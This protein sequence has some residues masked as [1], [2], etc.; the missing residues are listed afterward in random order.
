[1]ESIAK[2]KEAGKIAAKLLANAKKLAKPETPL[3]EIAEKI[4]N[5][6]EKLKVKFAFPINLSINEIAAH[7]TPLADD[8]TVASGLLK[9][10]IGVCIDGCISDNA[11]SIDLTPEQKYKDLIKASESAL[12]E[13]IKIAKS[14][15]EICEIGK[16]IAN[17]ITKEGFSPVR[18][19]SGHELKPYKLH[20]GLNIPNYDNRNRTKL[21]EGMI[22][23]VEPFAT[24]GAGIVQ[25]G[26]PSGI[27]ALQ[28]KKPVRDMT[29]RELLNFIEKEYSTLPFSSRWIT[30]K[31]PRGLLSL[32]LLEQA[33]CL[34]Q[35]AQLVE[36]SRQAVSQAE[37]T[38]LI[39]KN[40]A[41]VLTA[42]E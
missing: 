8:R 3:L 11:C 33:S 35:F 23:A 27:F 40:K 21:Q 15:I 2:W 28:E 17:Q 7:F 4:E 9:I 22:I 18:N 39:E 16:A 26:K 6:A 1:M 19:L 5:E 41:T 34:H 24:S 32:R 31:F 38:L 14:E 37:H 12:H 10:D 36:S 25:D 30:K 29:T 13:A 42:E 20:A